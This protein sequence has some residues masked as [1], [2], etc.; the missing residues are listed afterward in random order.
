MDPGT[1]PSLGSIT[2]LGDPGVAGVLPLWTVIQLSPAGG[3]PQAYLGTFLLAAAFYAVTA[4]IAARYVLG[5]VPVRRAVIVGT[6]PAALGLLLQQY[7]PALV[8]VVSLLADYV[9]IR[10][11]YRLSLRLAAAV[12][13]VHYTVSAILGIT[14]FNL[15]RLI[16]TMPG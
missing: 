7:G 5:S 10:F 11:T 1:V 4:H 2:V 6:V 9:A 3:P 14:L 15:V 8:I 16:G 12:S 13:V